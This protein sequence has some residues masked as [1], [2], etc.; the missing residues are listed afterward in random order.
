MSTRSFFPIEDFP[1][2]ENLL[3]HWGVIREEFLHLNAP[4]IPVNRVNKDFAAVYKETK[5][6]IENGGD[7]GWMLGWGG[8]K[9]GNAN[10]LQFGIFANYEPVVW[11]AD[12]M[13]KTMALLK[14][15]PGIKVCGL[16]TMKPHCYLATHTHPEIAIEDLLQFHI[17]L[18]VPDEGNYNYLNVA[19]E[20]NHNEL[21]EG[22][23]FDGSLDHFALN[24]SRQDRTILYLEF[25]KDKLLATD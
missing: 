19:G 6:H 18:D 4:T 3:N 15:I 22:V 10:W 12:K 16:A 24:A 14:E 11:A 7:Y 21:G 2:L 5:E 9:E 1:K 23:V 20:F 13:P 8:E 17:T 25:Q